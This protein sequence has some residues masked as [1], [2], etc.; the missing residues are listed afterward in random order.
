MGNKRSRLFIAHIKIVESTDDIWYTIEIDGVEYFYATYDYFPN[1]TELFE[2]AIVSEEYSLANGISV[3]MTK[4]ELLKRYPNMRIEGT[5]GNVI[6]S[7]ADWIWWRG[8]LL[9]Q[10]V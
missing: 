10:L 7:M 1:E 5:A 4:S 3:G 6:S 8:L 2:Y 9:G